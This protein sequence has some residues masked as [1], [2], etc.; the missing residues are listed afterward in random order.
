VLRVQGCGR[1]GKPRV[2]DIYRQPRKLFSGRQG[3]LV[4]RTLR[5]TIL[6]ATRQRGSRRKGQ[7]STAYG[8]IEARIKLPLGQG[9]W[10]ALWMLGAD[11]E[12]VP[13]PACGEIDIMENMDGSHC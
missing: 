13:W 6:A 2:E 3:N 11:I 10:P 8:K 1:L 4:I 7:S 5:S 12:T 9:I